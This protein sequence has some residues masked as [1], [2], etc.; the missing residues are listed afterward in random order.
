MQML[1]SVAEYIF[2]ISYV[3]KKG[4][5]PHNILS[6]LNNIVKSHCHILWILLIELVCA[7]V[8]TES[9]ECGRHVNRNERLLYLRNEVAPAYVTPVC[10]ECDSHAQIRVEGLCSYHAH[11]K[12]HI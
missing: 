3:S 5:E 12:R 4:S 7:C 2:I 11:K 8:I 1:T 10:K 6:P 9:W